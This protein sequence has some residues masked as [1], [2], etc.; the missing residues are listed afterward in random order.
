LL[1]IA[2]KFLKDELNSYI[3]LQ[4]GSST[5][6]INLCQVVD[7]TGKYAIKSETIGVALINIEEERITK[8][9]LP[10]Y[11]YVNGQHIK[12][13]PELK[14]NLHVII[15]ANFTHY[16][17][18]LKYLSFALTYFQSHPFFSPSEYP[19]L[20]PRITKLIV[21][22]LSLGYEQLNQIW[23]YIG[24]KQLPSVFYKVRLVAIQDQTLTAVQPPLTTISANLHRR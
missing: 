11:S 6:V 14:L 8:A 20:D 22:L 15:A 5:D 1:D 21:E 2:L 19:S 4:T 10:D 23:A 3:K 7:D 12:R 18:A 17:I 13:E 16:D 24:G 9:Q